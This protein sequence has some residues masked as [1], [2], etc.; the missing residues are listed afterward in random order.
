MKR[1]NFIFTL[2]GLFI[3]IMT[4]SIDVKATPT[5]GI[6][7]HL[8]EI[9]TEAK[10]EPPITDWQ[11]DILET[12]TNESRTRKRK[13]N[14]RDNRTASIHNRRNVQYNTAHLTKAG[15]VFDGPSGK[16]TYY[17][18]PMGQVVKYMEDLGYSYKYWIRDDGVKMYGDYVMCAADLNT[19]PK[20]TIIPTSLGTGIVCD[21][22]VFVESNA[23]QLDIAV[24]W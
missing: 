16:E 23:C 5:A 18:L 6:N 4:G 1:R 13:T 10:L 14:K 17:N 24:N 8:E 21:T 12:A 3:I 15:G 7:Q 11:K 20:G 19:R 2:T 22:G 9:Q